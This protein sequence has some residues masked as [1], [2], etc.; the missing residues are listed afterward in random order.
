MTIFF[1]LLL[2]VTVGSVL[3]LIGAGG[4][5]LAV[6][7]LVAALGLS[8]TAAT[9]SSTIIVGSAALVGALRRRKTGTVNVK[10]GLTFSAIGVLGTFLGTLLLRFIPENILLV[11]FAFLMFGSA[12]SMCCREVKESDT[13]K[14]NW[15]AVVVAATGVGILTGL[16]GIGGGFL[17]VP[18]LVLFLKVP[19]K[20][21]AG[22]SL[23]AITANSVL[24]LGLRFEFWNQIPLLEIAVFT[25]AAILASVIM[26]PIATKLP[27][28]LLQRIFAA[29]I[30]LVAIYL[31]ATNVN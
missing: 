19:T 15:F 27:T 26:S 14:P 11:L 1:G 3:G 8:A 24:A 21:A 20:V 28:K 30:T 25:A 6:P 29:I 10:V 18:A 16:L 23:V 13:T 7:G 17:I 4:A 9:T 22:T 31:I 12:Y 2:G 5:I